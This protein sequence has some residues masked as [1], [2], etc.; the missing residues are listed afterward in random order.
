MN[1]TWN[2]PTFF[3]LFPTE[4]F[5]IHRTLDDLKYYGVNVIEEKCVYDFKIQLN[6]K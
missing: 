1:D 4:T 2:C 6:H 5:I 3:F